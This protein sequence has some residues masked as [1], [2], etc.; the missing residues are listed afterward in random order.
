MNYIMKN[1]KLIIVIGIVYLILMGYFTFN[2]LK[3][4]L[5]IYNPGTAYAKVFEFLGTIPMPIMGIFACVAFLMDLRYDSK[6]KKILMGFLIVMNLSYFFFIGAFSIRDA[7]SSMF[8]PFIILYAL[9]GVASF[10]IARKYYAS[11]KADEFRKVV[12]VLLATCAIGV[13]GLDIIK[14]TFGRPRFYLLD[15]PITQFKYWFIIQSHEFN[16]SFPS[17]H[18]AKSA[19][20][21]ALF[22][23][24]YLTNHLKSNGSK[25][26]TLVLCI[27]FMLCT[28]IARMM[29]GMHYATDVLTGA[30]VVILTFL[31]SKNL[32]L[33][34]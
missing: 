6:I 7:I 14:T 24:P 29:D 33:D 17:G 12:R 9:W 34:K 20:P 21:F 5:W 27:T 25:A 4:A 10:F 13:I 28:M 16:S 26:I 19:M 30:V 23:L 32:I 22:V 8:V 2:D 1:K 18:A 11:D 15:D 3:I 31:I